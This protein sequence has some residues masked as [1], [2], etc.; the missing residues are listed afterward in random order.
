MK[1]VS[2][3]DLTQALEKGMQALATIKEGNHRTE[4]CV[5][6]YGGKTVITIEK[7]AEEDFHNE[8]SYSVDDRLELS[9]VDEVDQILQK[10]GATLSDLRTKRYR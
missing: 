8:S 3:S 1:I 7:F 6:P 4:I 5:F 10:Y 9:G 2:L